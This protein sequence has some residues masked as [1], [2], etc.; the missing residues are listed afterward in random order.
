[1]NRDIEG[2]QTKEMQKERIKKRRKEE[3]RNVEK[4]IIVKCSIG[5]LRNVDR[6]D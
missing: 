1:M 4:T 6:K 2:K 5:V 3:Q